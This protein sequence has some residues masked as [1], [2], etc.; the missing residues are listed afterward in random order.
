LIQRPAALFA[1]VAAVLLLPSLL[2]GTLNSHS[3]PQNLTWAAQFADQFRAGV[4]YPR[5]LADSFDRLGG[6]AFYFYPPIGFW[7]DALLSVVTFDLFSVSYRLSFSSLILL[8]ASGL[9]M[10]AWLK[11]EAST[12]RAALYG[13][14]AYMAAPYHLIDHYYR[15]A[16]AEFA[17]YIVLP[18]VALSIR[19]IAE[20][21]RFG[22]LLLAGS[23]AA[24]PMS[25]LPTS[26][27]ISLTAVPLYVLYRGWRLGAAKPALL[28]FCRCAAGGT[29][30]LGIAAIYLVPA[31]TLQGWIPADT[32]W[33]GDY[34][35]E[36]WFLR[37]P[38]GWPEPND[39]MLLMSWFAV[40]YGLS[41]LAVVVA[42][43]W[44]S[45]AVFWA[46][47]CFLGLALVA[48]LPPWF[49]KIPFTAKVQF[50]WRLMIV[51]EFAAITALCLMPWSRLS[52]LPL[53]LLV[54]AMLALIP[55]VAPMI[56]GIE[57]RMIVSRT[58]PDP[59]A[60]LKQFLPAG[61]PQKPKGGYAELSLGP[62]EGVPTIS[63]TPQART[64]RAVEEQFGA[65]RIDV[66]AEAPT[67]VVLRRF[68]FPGWRLEPAQV[69]K[70][71]DPLRLVS[72]EAPAGRGAF[73]LSRGSVREEQIGWLVSGLAIVVLA[74]WAA[75]L[76][77]RRQRTQ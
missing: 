35:L 58:N 64:C 61:Y 68:Y 8:W 26:L 71:T 23:Y 15:G 12:P 5:W 25:H 65:L 47:V 67:T 16:Y 13:A 37:P 66:E 1:V 45:E 30:G 36:N 63:C 42:A 50:P 7:V 72:F 73:T 52:R 20:G 3:S 56:V 19:R 77:R 62:V 17:A 48:G 32:F 10:H 9:S 74:G 31:L 54:A 41:A 55:G 51:V 21:R 60:D 57:A 11:E 44:R 18:L 22:P 24:L 75:V 27:L 4:L 43:A 76:R 38:T 49:W 33:E 28:F 34:Q 59:P 6:P 53:Y 69:V 40:A 2:L 14:L 70:P 46:A 39:M 29:L